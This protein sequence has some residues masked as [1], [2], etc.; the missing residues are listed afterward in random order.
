MS[1]TI[2]KYEDTYCIVAP[3]GTESDAVDYGE[4]AILEINGR[5]HLALLPSE[6]EIYELLGEQ[7][8][9]LEPIETEVEEIE[10]DEDESEH[11]TV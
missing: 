1:G 2:R 7:I 4:P 5:L 11:A 10:E 8:F 9:C 6:D 3:D